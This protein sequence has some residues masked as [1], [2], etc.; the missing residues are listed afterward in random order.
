MLASLMFVNQVKQRKQVNPDNVDEM[1][2]QAAYFD[3]RVVFGRQASV[4]GQR[5]KP[6]EDPD[7]DDH[8]HGVESGH[9]EIKGE[10]N[11]GVVRVGELTGMS[12]DGLVLEA[13]RRAGH[14]VLHKLIVVFD[15]LNAEES[16][17]ENQREDE[18]G[19]QKRATGGLGS[20]D[21]EYDG[22]A[23]ADE[24]RGVGGAERGVKS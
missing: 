19:D 12:G 5:E 13:E 15:A 17:A 11:L 21:G 6:H 16:A 7:A 8:V 3:G 9:D 1:P 22:Q 14:V 10:I 20:P 23:A 24:N 2:V 4:P 18:A